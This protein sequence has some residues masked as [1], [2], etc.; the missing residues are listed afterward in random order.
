MDLT[1]S[2]ACKNGDTVYVDVCEKLILPNVFTPNANGKDDVLK[3][4]GNN[5]EEIISALDDFPFE[6]GKPS[7]IVAKTTSGCGVSFMENQ[8]VWH[9]RSPP[10]E[11]V[12]LALK[13]LGESPI[14]KV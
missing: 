6:P 11:E 12:E 4:Y 10:I 2:N 1:Y 13:E 14:H 7:A 9:Y 5:I 8:A 3:V